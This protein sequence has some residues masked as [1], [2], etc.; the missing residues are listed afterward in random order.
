MSA[1]SFLHTNTVANAVANP[2]IKA[3]VER[4]RFANKVSLKNGQCVGKPSGDR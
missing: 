2:A 4:K 3:W 1:G